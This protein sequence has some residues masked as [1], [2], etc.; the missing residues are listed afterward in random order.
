M[1]LEIEN[2]SEPFQKFSRD[3]VVS[4]IKLMKNGIDKPFIVFTDRARFL[5]SV[6]NEKLSWFVK[7]EE[8]LQSFKERTNKIEEIRGFF[9]KLRETHNRTPSGFIIDI[10][11]VI[12]ESNRKI[13][14]Q[15][16]DAFGELLR[17]FNSLLFDL[18]I[19]KLRERRLEEVIPKRFRRYE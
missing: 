2:L 6:L 16:Y 9:Y 13:E 1:L 10:L 5:S 17:T 4:N 8:A 15:I 3:L 14:Y 7:T 18:H 12:P 11:V 19:I